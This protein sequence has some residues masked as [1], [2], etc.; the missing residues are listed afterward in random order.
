MVSLKTKSG[1]T[2]SIPG[3]IKD[4]RVEQAIRDIKISDIKSELL[5]ELKNAMPKAFK[6]AKGGAIRKRSK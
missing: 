2:I 4:R 5:K 1:V 3:N 6:K